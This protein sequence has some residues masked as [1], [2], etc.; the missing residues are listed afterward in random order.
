MVWRNPYTIWTFTFF[1]DKEVAL[2]WWAMTTLWELL[3]W[4]LE[5]KNWSC[6]WNNDERNSVIIQMSWYHL[7]WGL[8]FAWVMTILFW[9][10]LVLKSYVVIR[11]SL[12]FKYIVS[13]FSKKNWLIVPLSHKNWKLV[14][15]ILFNIFI[16]I[17]QLYPK[18]NLIFYFLNY[19]RWSSAT[20]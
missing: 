12:F 19:I 18:N 7:R 9:F 16:A 5:R 3:L 6:T 10:H 15:K 11:K 17:C 14:D 2:F 4:S 20:L 1:C 8:L 13:H